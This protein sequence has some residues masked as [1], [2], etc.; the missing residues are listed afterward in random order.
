[1][2]MTIVWLAIGF[3][4]FWFHHTWMLCL[5]TIRVLDV[6]KSLVLAF[7]GPLFILL[8]FYEIAPH[9]TYLWRDGDPISSEP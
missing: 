8:I 1:M 6:V 4:L 9:I 2:T 3:Y 5:N 7:T